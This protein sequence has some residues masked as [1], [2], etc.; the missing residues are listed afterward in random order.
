MEPLTGA[1]RRYL[2]GLA[3]PMKPQVVIGKSGLSAQVI[4]AINE[5]LDSHE[6]IKIR[7]LE[8]KDEKKAMSAEIAKTCRCEMAGMVGHVALFYRQQPDPQKRTIKLPK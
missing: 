1:L 6:L 8:F 2:R 3:N 7:F 5:A 4:D